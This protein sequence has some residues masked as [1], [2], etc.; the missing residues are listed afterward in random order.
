MKRILAL[1]I[2]LSC[3]FTLSG[4]IAHIPIVAVPL[5]IWSPTLIAFAI[6]SR[7]PTFAK[8]TTEKHIQ[9]AI[10]YHG[11]IRLFFGCYF[12]VDGAQGNLPTTFYLPAG[13]GDIIAAIGA[14]LLL[15][16]KKHL[17]LRWLLAWNIFAFIDILSVFFNV[18]RILFIEGNMTFFAQFT[19]LPYPMLPTLI[20]PLI[21]LTHLL[22]LKSVTVKIKQ[23]K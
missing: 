2:L 10:I 16:T 13:I 6:L 12:L 8:V 17:D 11:I 14:L 1:W 21:L 5:I 20:V 23:L 19:R 4:L 18:Q 22:M 3:A 9:M 15:A 7:P